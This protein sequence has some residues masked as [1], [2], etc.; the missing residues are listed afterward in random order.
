LRA[1][2]DGVGAVLDGGLPV[3][4][5][6][7]IT[8]AGFERDVWRVYTSLGGVRP[9]ARIAPGRWDLVVD[10]RAVELDED[11][12]FNRYRKLTL[13]SPLYE[14]LSFPRAQYIA[15]CEQ[16]EADCLRAGSWGKRWTQ[17]AAEREFGPPGQAG[18]LEGLG[19]PRWKQRAFYDF[20]KDLAP[21]TLELPLSRLAIWDRI[22]VG[23]EVRTVDEVLKQ[24]A[25]G[26]LTAER[27]WA[28]ALLDRILERPVAANDVTA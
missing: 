21:F 10:G 9:E 25:V 14:R 19:S 17:P 6:R 3:P 7:D 8:Q 13:D 18:D 23:E 5:A 16:H 26:V 22:D 15:F 24:Y 1:L 28:A 27:D 11:L 12:H 4:S 20:I 2:L